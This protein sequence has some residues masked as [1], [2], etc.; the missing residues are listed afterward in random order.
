M[1]RNLSLV[2][3][4]GGKGKRLGNIT[5]K[6]PKPLIKINKKPF[7]EYLIN[8]YQR[9]KFDK[10]YLIGHYKSLQFNK[11][12]HKKVFNFIK[13][14]FIKE[15]KALDTGGALNTLRYRI[16]GDILLINGDSYLDYDFIKF[17][18][19]I[20]SHS[21]HAMILVKNKTYKSNKKLSN[22]KISKNKQIIKAKNSKYMNAG[23]YFF[24]KEIFDLIKRNKSVSLENDILPIL[25]NK[26]KM[27]GIY[28]NDFFIDIGI[29]KNLDIAKQKLINVIRRPAIFLDRDGVLNEDTGHAYQFKKM[30][31]IKSSL[32]FLKNLNKNKFKFFIVTNQSGIA[33]GIYS[34]KTFLDLHAKIK[35]FLINKNIFIDDIRYCPHHPKFGI[36]KY[37]VNCKCRKPKNQMITDLIRYWN[38][39]TKKSIMIGDNHSDFLSAVKSNIKFY[40]HNKKNITKIIKK[41]C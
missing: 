36:K 4:C 34:E 1:K 11:I 32:D 26:K 8:F 13:C 19:F 3:L 20:Y 9:Y 21:S 35:E 6:T 24:K 31:W 16:K 15:K 30:K 38:I 18:K 5:K 41:I 10:I 7:I 17:Y 40:Y 14:E 28:S 25:I 22:L 37:K 12:F 39:N 2:I 29:K 23:I 33:R 27:K